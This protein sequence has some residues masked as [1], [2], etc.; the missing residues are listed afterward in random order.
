M[1]SIEKLRPEEQT[2]VL[3]STPELIDKLGPNQEAEKIIAGGEDALRSAKKEYG[4]DMAEAV[5]AEQGTAK[6]LDTVWGRIKKSAKKAEKNLLLVGV[7]IT[8]LAATEAVSPNV[9]EADK[10]TPDI[11]KEFYQGNLVAVNAAKKLGFATEVNTAQAII[12]KYLLEKTGK[13]SGQLSAEEIITQIEELKATTLEMGGAENS[14]GIK[15]I[16]NIIAS[17][18]GNAKTA[19][20]EISPE[21][22]SAPEADAFIM[23][24]LNL[25]DNTQ[26]KHLVHNRMLQERAAE[27]M[28][29]KFLSKQ[30]NRAS[31]R[32]TPNDMRTYLP[33]LKISLEKIE[34][35]GIIQDKANPGVRM[36]KK[37]IKRYE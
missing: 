17:L 30:I 9:A 35:S 29:Q 33:K 15:V 26:A 32:L 23:E 37:M 14:T 7:G 10:I 19:K 22:I 8:A 2:P 1:K 27:I 34:K 3:A 28:I 16:D 25:P 24:L 13:V 18:S 36:L 20:S 6:S 4:D 21:I 31:D 5:M 12:Q 11:K